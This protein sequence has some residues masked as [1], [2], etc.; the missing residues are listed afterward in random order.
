MIFP[1]N[2]KVA[3]KGEKL[4]LRNFFYF[5]LEE[6]SW[7]PAILLK[8]SYFHY[9]GLP[10]LPTKTTT[11]SL[12]T[13]RIYNIPYWMI[14]VNCQKLSMCAIFLPWK[15]VVYVKFLVVHKVCHYFTHSNTFV[16]KMLQRPTN[17][18]IGNCA[19]VIQGQSKFFI[20]LWWSVN[21]EDNSLPLLSLGGDTPLAQVVVAFS[22]VLSDPIELCWLPKWQVI[23]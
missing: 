3:C 6:N 7:F 12:M 1:V 19:N 5:I 14:F 21:I 4:P 9:H 20:P 23:T 2:Q 11:A 8:I 16:L 18:H 17:L 13:S 10:F 15:L 22:A